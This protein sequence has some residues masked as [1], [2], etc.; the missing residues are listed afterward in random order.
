M[1]L[2]ISSLEINNY[3]AFRH[4]EVEGFGQVNL[5][6]GKN[7]VGKTSLLEAIWLFATRGAPTTLARVLRLPSQA[8]RTV[9]RP[10]S[11]LSEETALSRLSLPR[12]LFFGRSELTY[13]EK[14]E[15]IIIKPL[16]GNHPPLVI[17][18]LPLGSGQLRLFDDIPDLELTVHLGNT[19]L[20]TLELTSLQFRRIDTVPTRPVPSYYV[21]AHGLANEDV[22][23]LWDQSSLTE[24]ESQV[25]EA[26]RLIEKDVQ[27]ISLVESDYGVRT[28]QTIIKLASERDPVPLATMGDGMTR[29]FEIILAMVNCNDGILLVDEIENGIH[30]AIQP[31]MWRLIFTLA[32]LLNIQVFATTH[33]L[34]CIRAFS[35]IAQN[36]RKSE[37]VVTSLRRR[38]RRPTDIIAVRFGENEME[39]VAREGLEVR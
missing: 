15:P 33:S 4:L 9:N 27:A 19:P 24:R 2:A 28:R 34:D 38:E 3:R 23:R 7:N 16:R 1:P 25:I 26:L 30:Y 29:L 8:F 35:Y 21:P 10:R 22:S 20:V 36:D 14:I 39:V 17:Q 18:V 37:G 12:H 31:E 6:V 5:I 32:R 11:M 13:G